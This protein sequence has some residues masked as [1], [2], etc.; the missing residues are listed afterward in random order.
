MT[1][2]DSEESTLDLDNNA[3]N[4]VKS[5]VTETDVEPKRPQRKAADKCRQL[6][7]NNLEDL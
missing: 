3:V 1:N 4:G 2:L 6:I 7:R 5:S